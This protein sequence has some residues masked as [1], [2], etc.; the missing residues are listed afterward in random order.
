ME[1]IQIKPGSFLMVGFSMEGSLEKVAYFTCSQHHNPVS[2]PF[3]FSSL[4]FS[5]RAAICLWGIGVKLS[6]ALEDRTWIGRSPK[7]RNFK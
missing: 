5:V 4:L 2:F 6:E 3:L 7:G 1:S